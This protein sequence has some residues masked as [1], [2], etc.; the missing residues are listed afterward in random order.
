MCS[1]S[2]V[3]LSLTFEHGQSESKPKCVRTTS[4]GLALHRHSVINGKG[5]GN[6]WAIC[7]IPLW[8]EIRREGIDSW[9]RTEQLGLQ[10]ILAHWH[11]PGHL[12]WVWNFIC[13]NIRIS[14]NIMA[15]PDCYAWMDH[16]GEIG[17]TRSLVLYWHMEF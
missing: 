3:L 12:P 9:R 17:E 1:F 11:L 5:G 15:V 7:Y 13:P 6:K 4:F 10:F 8:Q 14:H 2:I 16:G